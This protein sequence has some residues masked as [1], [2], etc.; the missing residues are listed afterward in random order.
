MA[1]NWKVGE[2]VKAVQIGNVEDVLDIGRRFPLFARLAA[3]TNEA[4][5]ALLDCV[6][7][8]VTARKLESVLKGEAQS[9]ENGEDGEDQA[10]PA[11]E[12]APASKKKD[13]PKA[14]A[15]NED[16]LAGKSPKELFAIAKEMGVAVEP[17][18][19]AE[20]YIKAIKKAQA[21]AAKAAKA[22]AAKAPKADEEDWGDEEPA[23]KPA[24]GG[25]KKD[26]EDEWDI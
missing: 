1:K 4:G 2:A 17:K 14:A 9:D 16:V 20:V 7:D 11:A 18:Q 12:P 3:Q 25:K 10:A 24:K 6:P 19:P 22:A 13:E 23:A 26:E 5:V 21:E 8:Y 15:S